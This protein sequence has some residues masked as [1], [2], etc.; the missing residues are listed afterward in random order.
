MSEAVTLVRNAIHNPAEPRHFMRIGEPEHWVT[1]TARGVE[2]ARS[3]RARKVKEV[4]LDVYDP[5]L[6]FPREDVEMARLIRSERTTH[7]PLKGDTEYFDLELPDGRI[8]NAAWSYHHTIDR[9]DALRDL[10]AFDA[11]L[12]RVT[13]HT[14]GD[15]PGA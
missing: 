8:E 3:R 1:A 6:Y 2:I 7:C 15:P 13:E 12:V 14:A 5:V 10:I 11:R 9:A 4:G